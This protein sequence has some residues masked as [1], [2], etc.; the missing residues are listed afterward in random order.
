MPISLLWLL[1][2]VAL[3]VLEAIV[4]TAF[5]ALAMGLSAIV[6]ALLIQGFAAFGSQVGLQILLWLVLAIGFTLLVRTLPRPT[7]RRR[8]LTDDTQ[9]K[10][11]TAIAP[12]ETG[13]VLY[14]GNSWQARCADETLTIEANQPVYIVDHRGTTLMV[15]PMP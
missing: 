8:M 13:R 2:G 3:C 12:G 10:T 7:Q 11:L 5:I 9:G 6:V 4:P 14:E 15:M 1:G